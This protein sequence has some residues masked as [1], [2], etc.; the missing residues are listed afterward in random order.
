MTDE[1]R[2]KLCAEL[3]YYGDKDRYIYECIIYRKAADEIERLVED[4]KHWKMIANR[5]Y[6]DP[7][8]LAQSNAEPVA[9]PDIDAAVRA[10]LAR[11]NPAPNAAV[12]VG[13]TPSKMVWIK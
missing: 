13:L 8:P 1:E 7:K 9:W 11:R 4:V 2:K 10:G 12:G 5:A 6:I 3:R